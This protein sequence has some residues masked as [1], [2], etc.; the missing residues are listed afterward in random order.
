MAVVKVRL[1]DVTVE[2]K[3]KQ[4][5]APQ[6]GASGTRWYAAVALTLVDESTQQGIAEWFYLIACS[7]EYKE[8][9]FRKGPVL[10]DRYVVV[11]DGFNLE[12]VKEIARQ[13]L[14]TVQAD[15]WGGFYEQMGKEF[16]HDD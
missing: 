4:L 11:Q 14:A 7:K 16:L 6:F 9:P 3:K 8:K 12:E 5:L 2:H 1:A 10:E 15:S 13:K